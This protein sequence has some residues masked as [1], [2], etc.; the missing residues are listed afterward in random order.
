MTP[1]IGHRVIR[2][3]SVGE[4]ARGQLHTMQPRISEKALDLA[5]TSKP[6]T[7]KDRVILR[8][9]SEF[10]SRWIP[11]SDVLKTC[12]VLNNSL[13]GLL[14]WLRMQSVN[15]VTQI[16]PKSFADVTVITAW[17]H[18]PSKGTIFLAFHP[19][20]LNSTIESDG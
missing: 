17:M 8:D 14:L 11:V 13:E 9:L 10:S 12:H 20:I 19:H 6:L 16:G 1:S 18:D 2:Y 5:T 3:R 4:E 7:E 15:K